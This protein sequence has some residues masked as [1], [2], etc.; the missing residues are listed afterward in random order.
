M[1]LF[2]KFSSQKVPTAP[3]VASTVVA[4]RG[5]QID[6]VSAAAVDDALA[7]VTD[8]AIRHANDPARAHRFED[9]GPSAWSVASGPRGDTTLHVTYGLSGLVDRDPAR[10]RII[11]EFAIQTRGP[12]VWWQL[13]VLRQLGAYLLTSGRD[14]AIGD[15]FPFHAPLPAAVLGPNRP[16]SEPDTH[17]TAIAVMPDPVLPVVHTPH[18]P[19][20]IRRLYGVSNADFDLFESWS[21]RRFMGLVQQRDPELVTDLTR[22]EWRDDPPLLAACA[23]ASADEGAETGFFVVPGLRW[24]PTAS[25]YRVVVPSAHAGQRI[26]RMLDGRLR[27][28]RALLVH[29]RDAGPGTA[30]GFAPG[31][32]LDM[33]ADENT[34]HLALPSDSVLPNASYHGHTHTTS[35]PDGRTLVWDFAR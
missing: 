17:L 27:F 18:G 25:G 26:A 24:E 12:G 9:G 3:V 31:G 22:G 11:Y 10:G 33:R 8:A 14:L 15:Y 5:R 1:G 32:A 19:L 35:A 29:G 13:D 16:P 30:V 7:A 23:A 21:C 6:P 34:L 28:G 2:D 4:G 20:E